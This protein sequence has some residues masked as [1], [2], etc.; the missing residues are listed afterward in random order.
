M[1]PLIYIPI[2]L[3]LFVI[4]Q[5]VGWAYVVAQV[6]LIHTLLFLLHP[7][8]RYLPD[9]QQV[10]LLTYLPFVIPLLLQLSMLQRMWALLQRQR[11]LDRDGRF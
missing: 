1:F 11:A 3:L 10:Q 8:M 6:Q 7:L 4:L 5:V 2:V 9:W